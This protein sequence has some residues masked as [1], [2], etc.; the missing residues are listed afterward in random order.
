MVFRA[1]HDIRLS[2]AESGDGLREE[3]HV[4]ELVP[5]PPEGLISGGNRHLLHVVMTLSNST[6]VN[7]L[8]GRYTKLGVYIKSHACQRGNVKVDQVLIY[9]CLT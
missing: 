8:S 9:I 7:W 6:S 2:D 5:C 3:V 4:L 1:T